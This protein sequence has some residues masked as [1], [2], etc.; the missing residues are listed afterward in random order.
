MAGVFTQRPA[1]RGAT[2]WNVRCDPHAAAMVYR[3]APHANRSIGLDV[4]LRVS[5]HADEVRKRFDHPLLK[6]VLD[7]ASVFFT[8]RERITF[9]DPLAAVSIFDDEVCTFARGNVDI[10]LI[11]PDLMG[12][13]HWQNDP[14]GRHEIAVD[15]NADRFFDR[16][17]DV[18]D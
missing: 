12:F 3:N 1:G 15:V 6:P 13:C 4:T 10:E 18:F 16:Y 14:Q 9:H 11:S 8:E 7:M 5:M 2:E 17:F